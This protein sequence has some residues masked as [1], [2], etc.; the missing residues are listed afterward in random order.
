MARDPIPNLAWPAARSPS[1][2]VALFEI[3]I[4]FLLLAW[5]LSSANAGNLTVRVPVG[6]AA[7]YMIWVTVAAIRQASA[8]L[9]SKSRIVAFSVIQLVSG[10]IAVAGLGQLLSGVWLQYA[11]RVKI[12]DISDISV[13]LPLNLATSVLLAPV[14]IVAAAT[15]FLMAASLLRRDNETIGQCFAQI[16]ARGLGALWSAVVAWLLLGLAVNSL[17]AI[18]GTA[19]AMPRALR[20]ID[21]F[22]DIDGWRMAVEFPGF[23]A[24]VLASAALIVAFRRMQPSALVSLRVPSRVTKPGSLSVLAVLGSVGAI[25]GWHIY[26]LHLGMIVALGPNAMI[27]GWGDVSRATN[28]WIDTQ[29]AAGRDPVEIASDL[30]NHGY[31]TMEEPASG[32][33]ELFPKLGDDLT[34]LAL[35]EDCGITIDAGIADNSALPADSWLEGYLAVYRPLPEV[36]YC[37][38]LAC[39]SPVVW[40]DHSIVILHSSHPS[41]RPQWAYNLFIDYLGVGAAKGPGGYCTKDGELATEYQG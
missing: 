37:I 31:W 27:V 6:V 36:S 35:R 16:R 28:A 26:I 17:L 21:L 38:R 7:I 9:P 8:S 15:A 18:V 40:H 11:Y 19:L 14:A 13:T 33:P 41:R 3:A 10:A 32:L 22:G 39:P 23:A 25:C 5:P 34:D 24:A 1:L 30:R 29:R 2:V 12:I 20:V 4:V